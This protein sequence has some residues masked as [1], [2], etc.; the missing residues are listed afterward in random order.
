MSEITT[1]LN[2]RY[3]TKAFDKNKKISNNDLDE[4]FECLRLTPS[5][6]GMQLWKFVV[7]EDPEI[8]AKLKSASWNQSQVEDCSQLIVFCVP[9]KVSFDHVDAY[10]D[11]MSKTRG[12][13]RAD[14]KS[15][16]DVLKGF[17]ENKSD[18]ETQMWAKKQTYIALGEL[19]TVCALKKIDACPMEGFDPVQYDEI[20]GL[21]DLNLTSAVVCPIGYRSEEDKYAK[22]P[23][24][25][26]S[27][28][29]V[30]IRK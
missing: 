25:R 16:E 1:A 30:I 13:T 20:L 12:V 9:K 19:L 29:E 2:W 23:K 10:L 8:K 24:V 14:L 27:K 15:F 28:E 6:F 21:G 26:F 7:V 11:E 22:L 18:E 4:I 3:A 17:L 5:S